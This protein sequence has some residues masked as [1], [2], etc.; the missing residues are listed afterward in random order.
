[1]GE[2]QPSHHLNTR[3]KYCV[4]IWCKGNGGWWNRP[5]RFFETAEKA[6]LSIPPTYA[7]FKIEYRIVKITVTEEVLS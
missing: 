7:M 1:M 6:R 4:E 3:V 2:R 5:I